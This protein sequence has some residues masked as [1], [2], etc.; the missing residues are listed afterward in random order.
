MKKTK[1]AA[2]AAVEAMN[3]L[4]LEWV[5]GVFLGPLARETGPTDPLWG[6]NLYYRKNQTFAGIQNIH[7]LH[8]LFGQL[9]GFFTRLRAF[10]SVNSTALLRGW[11]NNS[12]LNFFVATM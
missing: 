1:L 8:L 2:A 7:M 11:K 5:P 10:R 12:F 9:I 3:D 4:N 6:Y